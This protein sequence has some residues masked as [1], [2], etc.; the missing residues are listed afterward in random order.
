MFLS[1]NE[2]MSSISALL[3]A[4]LPDRKRVQSVRRNKDHFRK[5]SLEA[6]CEKE[7]IDTRFVLPPVLLICDNVEHI[8]S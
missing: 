7:G 6:P 8:N 3:P 1:F 5:A 2:G 4:S